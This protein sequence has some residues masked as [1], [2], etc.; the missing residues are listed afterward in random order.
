MLDV[1]SII[2]LEYKGPNYYQLRVNLLKDVKKEVQ[3]LVNSYDEI[4]A[5]VGM[6]GHIT[7]K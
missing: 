6:V 4:W 3:L 1:I 7:Y 2:G 5:K